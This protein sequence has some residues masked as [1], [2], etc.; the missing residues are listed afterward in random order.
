MEVI[1]LLGLIVRVTS[2]NVSI[3]KCGAVRYELSFFR[4]K[5]G[6]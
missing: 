6:L 5:T 1:Q 3:L 2:C 4:L